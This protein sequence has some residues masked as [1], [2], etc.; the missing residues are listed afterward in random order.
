MKIV[1]I[2]YLAAVGALALL[3]PSTDA[4]QNLRPSHAQQRLR[5]LTDEEVISAAVSMSARMSM[6]NVDGGGW[7][8][9]DSSPEASKSA[10]TKSA[11]SEWEGVGD[12]SKVSLHS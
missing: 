5:A 10:K 4:Q 12:W 3:T 9:V 7:W 2:N 8:G 1:S 11:K 6:A